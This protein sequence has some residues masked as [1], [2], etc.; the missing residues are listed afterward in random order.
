[1]LLLIQPNDVVM[2]YA[3][4]TF[5]LHFA[6]INTADIHKSYIVGLLFTLHFATINT[7]TE[8]SN[9]ALVT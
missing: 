8:G 7:G 2:K 3:E 9:P 5:T 1:M 6:T 4:D